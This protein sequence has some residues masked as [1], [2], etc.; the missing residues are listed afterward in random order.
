MD[1]DDLNDSRS[2]AELRGSSLEIG[3]VRVGGGRTVQAVTVG[4]YLILGPF[5]R[6]Y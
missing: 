4:A 5:P 2:L 3:A 1:I 6:Y